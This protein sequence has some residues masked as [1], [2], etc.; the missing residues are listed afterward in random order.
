[1]ASGNEILFGR[2]A[3]HNGLVTMEQLDE[4]LGLQRARAPSKH[5][6]QIMIERGLIDDVQARA[7]LGAQRRRLHRDPNSERATRETELA[8]ALIADGTIDRPALDRALKAQR[9]ML[10]RGLTPSLG[11]IL[12]QQG[13]VGLARLGEAMSRIGRKALRCSSCNKK[14]RA[15]GYHE[16]IDARC[17]KCG[18]KL[19]PRDEPAS[20][21][22]TD[23][24]LTVAVP[25]PQPFAEPADAFELDLSKSV[26]K[27][28]PDRPAKR[29][30]EG[31]VVGPCRLEKKIGA[32]GMGMV[33]R[34]RHIALDRDVA[35]KILS[36]R[37]KTRP[38]A[39]QRFL[40]EARAAARL[41]HPNILAV[42]DVGEERG[43]YFMVMEYVR[44]KS[45]EQIL[46]KKKRLGLREALEIT[47]QAADALG[48][49]HGQGIV[50]RDIKT[51][52]V[53]VGESGRVTI[54][55]FGLTKTIG[56]DAH[57][58]TVGAV[59]G[60]P[61]Y[62][63]PEQAEGSDVDGRS[64]LYS[65]G[66]TLF[67]LLTGTLPFNGDTHWDILLRLRK[68]PPPDPSLIR[69]EIPEALA[70]LVLRLLAK[71]PQA[72]PATGADV[73]RMVDAII[74]NLPA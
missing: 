67:E 52:N 23:Q 64:D 53:M 13:T 1:M 71:T 44:G 33:W 36:A 43:T 60:T 5:V 27:R 62:M 72:R 49:A 21:P 9:A 7:I 12:V 68:E 4:C 40:S 58:T 15:F 38:H 28:R 18:G 69:P 17:R 35:M 3:V 46:A 32:G 20:P 50:H 54:V 56:V 26:R 51:G 37:L 55:D 25:P 48:Y 16:G 19:E 70:K 6:G 29:L 63:S 74:E 31:D 30:R 41:N 10:E 47:R 11:D 45:L 34:A 14:Y 39:V 57:L 2:I 61:H 22:Q 73:V 65:L 66:V 42:H 8:D 24:G 59:L